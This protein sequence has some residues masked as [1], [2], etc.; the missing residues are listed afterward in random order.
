VGVCL[1]RSP[2][3][4]VGLLAT[5]RA[6]AAYMPLDPDD[7]PAR[8]AELLA[9]AG[10]TLVLAEPGW[11]APPGVRVVDPS[12]EEP[13]GGERPHA[14]R[15]G[16]AVADPS[17][18]DPG[19]VAGPSA[20]G[21]S[22][23]GP[24]DAAYLIFTSGSTG[25]PKGVVVPHRAICNRLL[26]MQRAYRLG[27]GEGVLQKTP[28]T[29]DVSVWEFFWPL[30]TGGRLVL[31]RPDG[32]RDPAHLA[33]LIRRRAVSTVHF[34]PS[35]LSAFLDHARI[36]GDTT[37][38]RVICSGEALPVALRRRFHAAAPAGVELHNLYG[39]TEAAVDVTHWRCTEEDGDTVPIG[40]PIDNVT[41]HV[42]DPYGAPVPVGVTG[43]LYLGGAGLADGYRGEPAMTAE[44]F[45]P[46][47]AA[48]GG[49]LY[50]TGDLGRRRPDGALEFLGRTDDQLKLRGMRVEPGEIEAALRGHEAV[51]E[52]AVLWQDDRLTG[53]VVLDR[54]V[55]FE[56][57]AGRLRDRLP[58][59]LVPAR[60]L[61][62]DAL[63]LT[64]NGKVDRAAL[65][66][67]A[68]AGLTGAAYVPPR[69]DR[70]AVLAELVADVLGVR[71]V[72]AHDDFFD[73]GGDSLSA[74]RL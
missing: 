25:R 15:P 12:D 53:H 54:P 37:L 40:R 30:I 10:V 65:R 41:V 66:A 4:V 68:A 47:P 39:P 35:M 38:R 33:G 7:P 51:R 63:P 2:A 58:A 49:R 11:A 73:A 71:R 22:A 13:P 72:G 62:H 56:E 52:A 34:V 36:D 28:A 32:H 24:D 3:L 21:P 29:F 6:G 50:R 59:H 48:R 18:E 70:E 14:E 55:G 46:D 74:L 27:E 9:A 26:W 5:L 23:A 43:E 69:D 44:R 64:R 31:A 16:V 19:S 57:L 61:A 1:R 42:L 60:W 20:A 8:I 45:G 67:A 17:G